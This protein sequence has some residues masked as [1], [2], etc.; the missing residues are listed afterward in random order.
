MQYWEAATPTMLTNACMHA[1]GK[2]L[3]RKQS[4]DPTAGLGLH[5]RNASRLS[6]VD[7]RQLHL[8]CFYTITA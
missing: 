1:S 2:V 3:M 4:S 8:L 6:L 5:V 7:G